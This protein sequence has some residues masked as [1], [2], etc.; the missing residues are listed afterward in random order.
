MAE[1]IECM[2]E[3]F[4]SNWVELDMDKW[5]A[6]DS[7]KLDAADLD[8]YVELLRRKVLACHIELETGTI[9]T[10][11]DDF[12][13]DTILDADELLVGWLAGVFYS[14]IGRRRILGNLS[15]RLSSSSKDGAAPRTTKAQK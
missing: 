4:E 8:G 10:K 1:R 7:K 13:E 14:A 12:D 15:A 3:G 5:T 6:R 9:L 11:P 2:A